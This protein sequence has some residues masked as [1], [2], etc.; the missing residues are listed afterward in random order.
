MPVLDFPLLVEQL[1][2]KRAV[3]QMD[4]ELYL[5]RPE[6]ST[7]LSVAT[8]LNQKDTTGNMEHWHLEDQQRPPYAAISA[9]FTPPALPT[10]PHTF[11]FPADMAPWFEPVG[12]IFFLGWGGHQQMRV[13]NVTAGANC[14]VTANLWPSSQNATVAATSGAKVVFSY[15]VF[16]SLADAPSGSY[17][18]STPKNNYLE[19]TM[20]AVTLSRILTHTKLYGGDLRQIEH[21]KAINAFLADQETSILWGIKNKDTS[22]Q[23]N[24]DIGVIYRCGGI[25]PDITTNVFDMGGQV[26]TY[27]LFLSKL[28]L[29][30]EYSLAKDLAIFAPTSFMSRLVEWGLDKVLLTED[31]KTFGME[32]TKLQTPFGLFPVIYSPLFDYYGANHILVLNLST[33][34]RMT[35]GGEDSLIGQPTLYLNQQLPT[36]PNKILD[37]YRGIGGIR[38]TQQMKS[39]YYT[40][41]T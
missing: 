21:R 40:N 39:G 6:Y 1:E 18:E 33:V 4:D 22:G 25:I 34:T 16:G 30:R 10:D 2:D 27:S 23:A 3:L 35:L 11:T 38:F 15:P 29:I 28:P 9:N 36:Q 8:R 13:T 31:S 37:F 24:P 5:D 19:Q 41:W 32:I 17:K 26:L 7:I 12:T 20:R 14:T